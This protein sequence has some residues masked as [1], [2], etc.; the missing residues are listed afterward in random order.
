[1]RSDGRTM[2]SPRRMARM[3]CSQPRQE[4]CAIA[5]VTSEI[6]NPSTMKNTN[7]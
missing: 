6:A 3:P 2:P 7:T 4:S 1:M 5:T